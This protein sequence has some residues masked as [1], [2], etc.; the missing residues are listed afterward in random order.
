MPT[1]SAAWLD[2]PFGTLVVREA[3]YTSPGAGEIVVRNR[4]V[5]MNPLDVVKQSTGDLMYGWLPYS[6]ILGVDVAGEVMEVGA[7]VTR[8]AVGDRVVG[9]AVG[10]E[11]KRNHAAEGGFQ[12]YTVLRALLAAP[13]PDSMAFE[14]AAVLPLG[15]STAASALFQKDQLGLRHPLAVRQADAATERAGLA[16]EPREAV[17]VWGGS[18]SVGSNAIQLA[19]AAG[20]TVVTTASPRN[21][22]R[23][24]ELGATHVFDYASPTVVADVI[25]AATTSGTRVIG[26]LA[27]GTGSAEPSV[28]IAAGTGAKRV[29]MASPSVSFL[30]LP[31]RKGPSVT[32][33]RVMARLVASNVALQLRCIPRGIRARFVWGSSLMNNEVGP[34]L[35]EEFLPAALAEGRYIA[36]PTAQV[37]GSGL[38]QVQT[39]LD[40]L[41]RGVSARKVVV[42]L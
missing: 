8:F 37:I 38:E 4:A 19:V 36:A 34:M 9:Y 15:I 28:A 31:R 25:A 18:T 39:A 29:A 17:V 40:V 12:N 6:M 2:A 27:V 23:M 33:V 20:Y 30:E 32:F 22:D 3:P 10:M 42:S 5:A 41:G 11:K 14:D 24:R 16:A 7:G 13:I 35:W 1:N 21:H 26:V